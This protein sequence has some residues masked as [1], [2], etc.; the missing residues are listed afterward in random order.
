[1]PNPPRHLHDAIVSRVKIMA[2][3]NIAERYVPQDGHI[4]LHF[5]GRDV[6]VRVATVPTI[7]G[8]SVVM[9]LLDKTSFLFGLDNLGFR[10]TDPCALP[11]SA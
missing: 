11:R 3:M 8:E 10:R 7:Y 4:D 2:E 6:D 5:E 1:M 9:R